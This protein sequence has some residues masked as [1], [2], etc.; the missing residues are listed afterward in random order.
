MSYIGD[1]AEDFATLN[2]KFMTVDSGGVPFVLAGTPVISVYKGNNVTQSTAGITLT[3]S[4]DSVVGMNNVL[5][6][7][8]ADAFYAIGFDYQIVITTGTVDGNSVVGYVVGEFSIE[9]RFK[10]VNVTQWLGVAVNALVSG[11]VD[12]DVGAKTG[13]VALSTQE[14]AD[15][16][17][18]ALDVVNTDTIAE[19]SQAIPSATPTMRTAVMLLYMAMRNKLDVTATL[20][21]IHNDAGTVITKK[22]LSDDTTTYSE[23]EMVAGP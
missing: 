3:V 17:V 10:E 22:T 18:E 13:N 9:N 7:L 16:N 4:F 19:L 21:E 8:S 11:R 5:I 12:V 15:V 6:D 23:A 1:Y 20:K 14:K 2:T